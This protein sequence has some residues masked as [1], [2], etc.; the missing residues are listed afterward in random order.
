M[1]RIQCFDGLQFHQ[2][3]VFN[4]QVS[5]VDADNHP[6][7][8]D[9]MPYCWFTN[10]PFFLSSCAR[11]FSYSFSANPHLSVLATINAQPIIRSVRPL[12]LVLSVYICVYLWSKF[13]I[14]RWV[15]RLPIRLAL[16]RMV[17]KNLDHRYTQMYTD[18]GIIPWDA[19]YRRW[20]TMSGRTHRIFMIPSLWYGNAVRN[21]RLKQWS[22][23]THASSYSAS[24][25]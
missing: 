18:K 5:R 2:R 13:L 8:M 6:I 7:I 21:S 20:A 24:G 9:M 3:Y 19:G 14:V 1:D 15:G 10:S 17:K 22:A 4:Q 23:G 16:W 25:V 11:E 12:R